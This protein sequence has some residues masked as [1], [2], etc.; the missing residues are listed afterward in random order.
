MVILCQLA[1]MKSIRWRARKPKGVPAM[2][3]LS[4]PRTASGWCFWTSLTVLVGVILTILVAPFVLLTEGEG[5]ASVLWTVFQSGF[6]VVGTAFVLGVVC[7]F[8]ETR[9]RPQNPE[10]KGPEDGVK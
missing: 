9:A 7:A 2:L 3:R 6:A 8:I 4:R 1:T 5:A 10:T